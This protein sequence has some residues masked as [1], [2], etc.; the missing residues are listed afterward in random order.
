MMIGYPR[1]Q[2]VAR[3][4]C[5]YSS[6]VV[7]INGTKVETIILEAETLS[8]FTYFSLTVYDEHGD[9]HEELILESFQFGSGGKCLIC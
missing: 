2:L 4:S 8:N 6:S 9:Q 3:H 7:L 1:Y 5:D